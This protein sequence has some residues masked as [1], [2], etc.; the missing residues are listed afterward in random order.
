[1]FQLLRD[2]HHPLACEIS[3]YIPFVEDAEVFTGELSATGIGL[4]TGAGLKVSWPHSEPV[5][6]VSFFAGGVEAHA[7]VAGHNSAS[8]MSAMGFAQRGHR[9]FGTGRNT[10]MM[11]PQFV[12]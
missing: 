6:V 7:E 10:W 8:S 12:Q 11:N 2:N 9:M 4:E 3:Y 5:A 1:M